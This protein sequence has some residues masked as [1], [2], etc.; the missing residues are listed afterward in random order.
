M[1]W[2]DIEKPWQV[3]FEQGWK[4]FKKG[5]IP[6]GPVIIN[7][8][9]EIISVGR[10]RIYEFET[11]NPKISH[12]EME[13]VFNLDILKHPSVKEYILYTCM[14]PCPMCFGTIVMSNF[15]KLKIASRDSYC[16]AVHYCKD[17]P[18]IASKNMQV[19]FEGGILETLQLVLQSYFE[20]RTCNGEINKVVQVFR[21]DNPIAVEIAEE[22][23]R[24]RYLDVCS[25]NGMD[26]SDVFNSIISRL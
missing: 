11:P 10:N 14:E 25:Q 3:S 7:E 19:S 26:I 5:S 6:I 12:A 16:G 23:Y 24:D 18:Y 4:A 22:F 15:R 17:D 13:C 1:D 20:L 21:K 8:K 2:D 9:G